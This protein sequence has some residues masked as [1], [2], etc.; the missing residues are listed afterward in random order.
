MV[1]LAVGNTEIL[2]VLISLAALVALGVMVGI[3]ALLRKKPEPPPLPPPPVLDLGG[4]VIAPTGQPQGPQPSQPGQPAVP[5]LPVTS[6]QITAQQMQADAR[7]AAQDL[8]E[9]SGD[10]SNARREL[11]AKLRRREADALRA[12]NMAFQGIDL[13]APQSTSEQQNINVDLNAV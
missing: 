2:V 11:K 4:E 8:A 6:Q 9:A 13:N 10:V 3:I 12:R 1:I 7:F 5:P